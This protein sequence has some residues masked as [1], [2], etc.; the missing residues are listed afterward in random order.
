MGT[1]ISG[2]Q[3]QMANQEEMIVDKLMDDWILWNGG[4]KWKLKGDE[5]E[6]GERWRG[7]SYISGTQFK[8]GKSKGHDGW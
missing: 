5:L 8:M 1:N 4:V 7:T 2:T 3:L 6:R